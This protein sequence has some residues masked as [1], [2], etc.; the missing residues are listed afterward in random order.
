MP[1]FLQAHG[2]GPQ[3]SVAQDAVEKTGWEECGECSTKPGYR[4][5]PAGIANHKRKYHSEQ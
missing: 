2:Y 1:H 5:V 4:G 3:H